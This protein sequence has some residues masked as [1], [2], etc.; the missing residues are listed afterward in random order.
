MTPREVAYKALLRRQ[1]EDALR[2]AD[3]ETALRLLRRLEFLHGAEST[4]WA[5]DAID[6]VTCALRARGT[7]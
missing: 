4:T 1:I 6:N 7:L 3:L 5:A 2:C